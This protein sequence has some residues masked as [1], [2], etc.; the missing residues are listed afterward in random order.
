MR[1]K[2]AAFS[3]EKIGIPHHAKEN[4]R[5]NQ[6][7]QGKPVWKAKIPCDGHYHGWHFLVLLR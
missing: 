6:I 4:Q 3:M 1:S 7:H 2:L 5:A